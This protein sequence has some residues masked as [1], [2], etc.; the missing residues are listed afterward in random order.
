[1]NPVTHETPAKAP[2][3]IVRI[4]ARTKFVTTASRIKKA[5]EIV[6]AAPNKR[7]RQNCENI[8]GPTEIPRAS[9]VNTEANRTP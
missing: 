4:I 8:F 9:P 3:K 7:L 1:M 5:D 6:S 2:R